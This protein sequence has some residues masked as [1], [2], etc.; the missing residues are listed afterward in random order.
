MK[1]RD[2][3]ILATPKRRR[4]VKLTEEIR[5]VLRMLLARKE[6]SDGIAKNERQR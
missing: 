5:S 3:R 2:M 1:K 4:T 6:R